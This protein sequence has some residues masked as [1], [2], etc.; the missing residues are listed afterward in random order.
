MALRTHRQEAVAQVKGSP[1]LQ[2]GD[3]LT[4][5]EFHR[6]YKQHPEIKKAEL[7]DGVVYMGSPVY[8]AHGELHL[9]INFWIGMYLTKTP[10]IRA[11]DN[12]SVRLDNEDEV[13]P[14][15]CVWS[16]AGTAQL[17]DQGML[18]GAPD[19][20]VEV[21]ASSASYDLHQKL[22]VY[23][24]SGVRE[25][26]VLLAY[27][28]ETRWYHLDE[29]VFHLLAVDGEGI[30]RSRIFPGLWLRPSDLW[31]GDLA[32]IQALV[33]QGLQTPEHADFIKSMQS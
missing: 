26:L 7:V 22:R 16:N 8:A 10:G 17:T 29:G 12:L 30:L 9:S 4:A 23:Q 27:E 6:R 11:A 13:Q 19:L 20:V 25:Y 15:V 33:Q 5:A 3:R 2:N 28:A 32:A 1:P 18:I 24:R 21:A 31:G 14:D